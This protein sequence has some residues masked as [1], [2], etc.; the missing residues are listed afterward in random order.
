MPCN[1]N[2]T[3]YSG[4]LPEGMSAFAL[5]EDPRTGN[6]KLHHF[7]EVLFM[8]VTATL[9]GMNGFAQ[10][11]QFCEL[12]ADWLK[13]WIRLPHGVPSAQ[14]FSNL[15]ALI[16]PD[17]FTRCLSTHIKN[18]GSLRRIVLSLIKLDASHKDSVPK[19][20]LRALLDTN[21]RQHILSLVSCNTETF[22]LF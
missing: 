18:L 8:A 5:I 16:D 21:F 7:G 17:Q 4:G 6:H 15:F 14:T 10:I 11:R 9:C 20:R 12:Q 2:K 13:R 19:K 22:V 3:D 1:P